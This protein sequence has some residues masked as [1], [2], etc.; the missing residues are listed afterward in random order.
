[1]LFH[2]RGLS[3]STLPKI[4]QK[5]LGEGREFPFPKSLYAVVDSLK[6]CN[7]QN[8]SNALVVDFFAGSGTT[9]N[10]INLLNAADNGSRQCILVTNN[11]VSE[12][13]AQKL[14]AQGHCNGS[15]EW[16]RHGICQSITFPRSEYTML[17][18]RDDGSE[19][20]GEY[21]TGRTVTKEKPRTFKQLGFIEGSLLALAQRKQL[22]A[23]VD[24]VPQSKITADMGF[25]VDEEIPVSILF[26]IHQVDAWLEAL[27]DQEHI[28]DFYIVTQENKAFN[29]IKQQI[30]ELLGPVLIEEEEKRPLKDGF[31]ANLEYFKLDFLDPTEV[32]MGRQFAAIL[33]VLWMMAGSCGPLPDAPDP[34]A[35]WLIPAD[36]PF[37]VLIQERRFKDFY[38]HIE[39][40]VDLTYIF[41]VTDSRDTYHRLREEVSAAHV[42]Q[43]YKDYLENFKINFGKD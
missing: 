4:L 8:K 21:L 41:I 36:C 38:R 29:S 30:Q 2:A 6:A 22:V 10:A 35:P 26:D 19:L 31:S 9:L 5:I 33:P 11:E 32:Q 13:E 37:A 1:L 15:E 39:G 24:R 17:G 7:I 23:L 28:T 18:R 3:F 25:F 14:K 20:V 27:E 43:L 16:S 34:H 42:V 40:R 12:E